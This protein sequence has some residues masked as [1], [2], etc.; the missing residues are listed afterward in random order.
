MWWGEWSSDRRSSVRLSSGAFLLM[1]SRVFRYQTRY[2]HLFLHIRT[3]FCQGSQIAI[4]TRLHTLINCTLCL[5]YPLSLSHWRSR[6]DSS[7]ACTTYCGYVYVAILTYLFIY[8]SCLS[9][10]QL[11]YYSVNQNVCLYYLPV[12]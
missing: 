6:C 5:V 2:H 4:I 3:T 1:S 10:C 12:A 9:P 11:F 7:K 8:L